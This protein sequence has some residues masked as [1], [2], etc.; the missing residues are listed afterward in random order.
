MAESSLYG[1]YSIK[2]GEEVDYDMVLE[3]YLNE[4]HIC[5]EYS[6]LK[7]YGITIKKTEKHPDGRKLEESKT[8]NDIFYRLEDAIT[9]LDKIIKN[10]VTPVGFRD[11]V[12][13]YITDKLVMN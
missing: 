9:F 1:T 12:E 10:S 3:Y 11:V 8:I 2:A 5:K 4:E 13:E 7:K 6:D